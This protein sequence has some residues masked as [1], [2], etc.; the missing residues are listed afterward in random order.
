M[1]EKE[2]DQNLK[3]KPGRSFAMAALGLLVLTLFLFGD[4]LLGG[5][6]VVLSAPGT[7]V[8]SQYIYTRPFGFGELKKGNLPLWNPHIF[9]GAPFFGGF[10]SALL[11]PLN[12]IFLIFP[13]AMAINLGIALHV[14]L[15]GIFT[16]LWLSHR[17]L[18]PLACFF[19][20][21]LLMF[22]GA[23]FMNVYA[24]H[25]SNLSTM[26]WAPLLF[27][28]LDGFFIA[29]SAGWFLLGVL[30]ITMQFLGGHPQ[31]VYYTAI[32]AFLYTA[33]YLTGRERRFSA[34][35]G[36]I[37]MYAGAA[38][39]CAVQLFTGMDAA[40]E[41][42]RSGGLSFQLAGTFSFPPENL[43]TLIC[44]GF[45]GNMSRMPYWGRWY[46]WE[47]NI[48]LG[49]T[50]AVFALYG[51][52]YGKG[53]G[54]LASILMAAA[55]FILALGKN[56]PLYWIFY[57]LVPFYKSFRGSS[58]FIFQASL[59][60]VML[61]G[62]GFD[63]FI[64]MRHIRKKFLIVVLA[65]GMVLVF[66]GLF[67]W[68]MASAGEGGTWKGLVASI[69]GTGES[70]LDGELLHN[71]DFTFLAR[72]YSSRALFFS[73]ALILVL[74]LFLYLC[75]FSDKVKYAVL[76]LAVIEVFLF[77]RSFR[78]TFEAESTRFPGIE[79]HL[80]EQP[81]DFRILNMKIPN[82]AMVTGEQ[83]VWGTA[84][85]LS[86]RYAEFMTF[87]QGGNPDQ[88][89]QNLSFKRYHPLY[90]MLRCRFFFGFR[91]GDLQV[92]E[93]E[94]VLPR[95]LFIHEWEVIPERDKIFER[96][97]E[98]DFD[99]AKL[100]ILESEPGVNQVESQDS[101]KGRIIESSTDR[102]VIEAELARP[103]IL[104][105]TDGYSSGWRALGL[106]GSVQEK[107]NL[108]PADYVL[109]AIPLTL[110]KHR[111]LLE[112]KPLAFQLGKW[113]SLVSLILFIAFTAWYVRKAYLAGF[114]K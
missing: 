111:I 22:S 12:L 106:P 82:S 97:A 7:D 56:L 30:A 86:S 3:S 96:M 68:F 114:K 52:V 99:P 87:T 79:S 94:N 15:C 29:P 91:E 19:S 77:A 50:G 27:L 8:F 57:H 85:L 102:K 101:P 14:F 75:R 17:N 67:I 110:G 5:G 81:G 13:A 73:G 41:S 71:E 24:G 47:M 103:A 88:A 45:F 98:E 38:A 18:H 42:V 36:L 1:N 43:L 62:M 112:Y 34:I 31:H 9:S 21:V 63:R 40:S 108:L 11:Y 66:L 59:F 107:Y 93:F 109:Q 16:Y 95:L 51:C 20:A 80:A 104:L 89:S 74:A 25:L 53:R 55:L 33:L 44:P 61:S 49:V 58:K 72:A 84:P 32:A 46:L 92:A 4:V 37:G 26:T 54:R 2:P 78:A 35:P 90:R 100:V 64:S 70:Y 28:A 69:H 48:F 76:L 65:T 10:E 83:D 60:L 39:L 6:E 23:F 113:I 105:L